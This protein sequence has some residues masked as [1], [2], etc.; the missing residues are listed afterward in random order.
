MVRFCTYRSS[1]GN[2]VP[3]HNN[4]TLQQQYYQSCTVYSTIN[5]VL[6]TAIGRQ[7]RGVEP[8]LRC[9]CAVFSLFFF[10][11]FSVGEWVNGFLCNVLYTA[12][13]GLQMS[14]LEPS[15]F[16]PYVFFFASFSVLFLGG[17]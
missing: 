4:T 16:P 7:M 11:F 14:G 8:S 12:A 15:L 5:H 6:F 1:S 9:F 17:E 10:F 2:N 13:V 3:F